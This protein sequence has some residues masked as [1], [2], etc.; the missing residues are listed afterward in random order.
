[1]YT[2]SEEELMHEVAIRLR[3]IANGAHKVESIVEFPD[4]GA[5]YRITFERLNSNEILSALVKKYLTKDS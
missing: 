4:N 1:M 2:Q 3:K 5:E